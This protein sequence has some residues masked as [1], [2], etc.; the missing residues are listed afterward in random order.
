M[1]RPQQRRLDDFAHCIC[2]STDVSTLCP[3][4]A[5]QAVE[6]S[7]AF[8]IDSDTNLLGRAVANP[9][10]GRTTFLTHEEPT[11]LPVKKIG[12]LLLKFSTSPNTTLPASLPSADL[13][14]SSES[15]VSKA[16][17]L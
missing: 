8:T 17:M 4:S 10:S 2:P 5:P 15:Q 7:S 9:W 16:A 3:H 13:R 11:M 1:D 14:P 6:Q 12:P